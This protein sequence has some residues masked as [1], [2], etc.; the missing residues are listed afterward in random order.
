MAGITFTLAAAARGMCRARGAAIVDAAGQ[1]T[2]TPAPPGGADGFRLPEGTVPALDG[3]TEFHLL[4]DRELEAWGPFLSRCFPFPAAPAALRI[5]VARG[6]RVGALLLAGLQDGSLP[7]GRL[8]AGL[9]AVADAAASALVYETEARAAAWARRRHL[10]ELAMLEQAG[11]LVTTLA[12]EEA[13]LGFLVEQV[14]AL[15]GADLVLGMVVDRSGRALNVR[16][17]CASQPG[18]DRLRGLAADVGHPGVCRLLEERGPAAFGD[19]EADLPLPENLRE[20]LR[21]FGVRSAYALP[22]L[23][24]GNPLGTL[25]LAFR[26]PYALS[27]DQ[28]RALAVLA[29]YAAIAVANA[30]T[31]EDLRREAQR[32]ALTGIC[33]HRHFHE[34]TV[35][36]IERARLSGHP[37]SLLMVDLDNFRNVNELLGYR[38]GDDV[39]R[40]F[41]RF[42]AAQ[43]PYPEGVARYGGNQFALLLPGAGPAA[44]QAAAE[45][46]REKIGGHRFRAVEA[47]GPTRPLMLTVSIGAATFPVDAAETPDLVAAAD[48]A[49]LEAQRR[50]GDQVQ[51]YARVTALAHE[52]RWY[53]LLRNKVPGRSSEVLVSTIRTFLAALEAKDSYTNSHSQAVALWSERI[54]R[55]LDLPEERVATVALGGLLHDIGKIGIP[56][57]V[58]SKNGPLTPAEYVQIKEHPALGRAILENVGVAEDVLEIVLHHQERFDGKGYPAGL[59][60]TDIPLGARIVAVADAFHSMTSRRPYRIAR[61]P[62]TALGEIQH[63]AGIMFDPEVVRAFESAL[64]TAEGDVCPVTAPAG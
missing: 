8:S 25:L 40:E 44:A 24:Q 46:L 51:A 38:V 57:T 7:E 14:R 39:L 45:E 21:P 58:L 50:G 47:A 20:A 48:R 15:Q 62:A 9:G 23:W 26:E 33:S 1:A 53:A 60:G 27:E 35:A 34:R 54:A 5:L 30:R 41:A 37:L 17:A 12:D 42:L 11:R 3:P 6:R 36:E 63:W 52:S 43:S 64:R 2:V 16:G 56:D 55:R 10:E 61:D 13:T 19:L 32:D 29:D 18:A 49:L 28:S 59:A 31:C 4:D 22:L